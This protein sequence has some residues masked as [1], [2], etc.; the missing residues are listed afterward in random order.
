MLYSDQEKDIYE[1][2]QYHQKQRRQPQG[3]TFNNEGQDSQVL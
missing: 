1:K 2:Y 3:H